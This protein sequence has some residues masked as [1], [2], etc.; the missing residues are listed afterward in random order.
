LA[1]AVFRENDPGGQPRPSAD[2]NLS[3]ADLSGANLNGADVSQ[4]QLEAARSLEG[5]TIPD[6]STHD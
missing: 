2:A 4:E 1:D 3:N 6:G 5:A